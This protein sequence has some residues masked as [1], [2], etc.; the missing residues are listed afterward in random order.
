MLWKHRRSDTAP[1]MV[2]LLE[3]GALRRRGA[4]TFREIRAVPWLTLL[5][6]FV[7]WWFNYLRRAGR[8]LW[9]GERAGA[10]AAQCGLGCLAA[11]EPVRNK[12]GSKD[13]V[14]LLFLSFCAV[15]SRF[16]C[17]PTFPGSSPDVPGNSPILPGNFPIHWGN[18]ADFPGSSPDW[19]GNSKACPGNSPIFPGNF[20]A[21][22][23]NSPDKPG[24]FPTK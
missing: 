13:M 23:G 20:P 3:G 7:A 10:A 16:L 24:S 4:P 6:A 12:I 22:W 19:R 18:S 11:G 15:F 21:E 9:E 8:A 17:F 14:F 1:S 2:K 5:G